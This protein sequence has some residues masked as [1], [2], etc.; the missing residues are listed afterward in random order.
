MLFLSLSFSPLLHTNSI[1]I[2]LL[3]VRAIRWMKSI[4]GMSFCSKHSVFRSFGL[5]N[6]FAIVCDY[7]RSVFT[8]LLINVRL[9]VLLFWH[10]VLLLLLC[11]YYR[12]FIHLYIR[13]YILLWLLCFLF[14]SYHMFN[15]ILV[16]EQQKKLDKTRQIQDK[17]MCLQKKNRIRWKKNTPLQLRIDVARKNKHIHA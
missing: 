13:T 12:L 6:F 10:P 9:Q 17:A 16:K 8:F 4:F 14:E 5:E 2:N 3:V 7:F 1:D 11:H 15:Y